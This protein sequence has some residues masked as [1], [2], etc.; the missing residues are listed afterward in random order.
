MTFYTVVIVLN[1]FFMGCEGRVLQERPHELL[2]PPMYQVSLVKCPNSGSLI[3]EGLHFWFSA[4]N[5]RV[6]GK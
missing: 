5:I 1:G 2:W 3:G 4:N 6:K